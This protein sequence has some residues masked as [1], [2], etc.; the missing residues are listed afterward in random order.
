M[1]TY[2][3]IDLENIIYPLL[4]KNYDKY[5]SIF[6]IT[7]QEKDKDKYLRFVKRLHN[8]APYIKYIPN[9]VPDSSLKD[10]CD[11]KLI[12]YCRD[13]FDNLKNETNIVVT[14]DKRLI[15]QFLEIFPKGIYLHNKK[16]KFIDNINCKLT[17]SISLLYS[18]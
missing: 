2:Y 1:K 14:R 3:H 5:N 6:V 13:N 18:T 8:Y 11:S 9:Q 16:S 12:D 7:Y 10:W 15:T 4:I 17:G